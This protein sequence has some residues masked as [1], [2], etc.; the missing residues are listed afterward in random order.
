LNLR[1]LARDKPCQVR[2]PGCDGGGET[3]VL[4]HYRLSGISGTGYKSPDTIGAWCC[5]SCHNEVDT[6]GT[7]G[8]TR[9]ERMLALAE[10]V[11][12]TLNELD[13]RGYVLTEAERLTT[14]NGEQC[15]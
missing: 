7:L 11:F 2:L 13:Q 10:G 6:A 5:A 14:N 9:H 15:G 1:D 4:A 12:R 8:L 3:T